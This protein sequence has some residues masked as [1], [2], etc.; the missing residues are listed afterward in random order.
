MVL[1]DE[2]EGKVVRMTGE[3]GECFGT[4]R[5]GRKEER[6]EMELFRKG[7]RCCFS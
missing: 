5:V 2:W 6:K 3:E 4:V 7:L 1:H